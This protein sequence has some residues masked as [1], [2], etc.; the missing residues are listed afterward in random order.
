MRQS[1]LGEKMYLLSLKIKRSVADA[2]LAHNPPS[3]WHIITPYRQYS[4]FSCTR[5]VLD[6]GNLTLTITVASEHHSV[7]EKR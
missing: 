4:I 2:D 5:A 6:Q 3:Y 7:E 1:R